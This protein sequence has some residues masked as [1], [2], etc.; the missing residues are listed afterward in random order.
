MKGRTVSPRDDT[1]TIDHRRMRACLNACTNISTEALEAGLVHD[2]IETQAL[3][4]TAMALVLDIAEQGK[5]PRRYVNVARLLEHV[6]P[7][8]ERVAAS[9]YDEAQLAGE[10]PV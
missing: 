7:V 10:V 1:P 5:D 8:N 6:A 3:L 2:V 4:S 9:G